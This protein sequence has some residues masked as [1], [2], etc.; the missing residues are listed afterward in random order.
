MVRV[1]LLR[2]CDGIRR[3]QVL[4]RGGCAI[5]H[6]Q[7]GVA[8]NLEHVRR[9]LLIA[10]LL[11]FPSLAGLWLVA[12]SGSYEAWGYPLLAIYLVWVVVAL[13]STRIRVVRILSTSHLVLSI[14]WLGLL[15][16]RLFAATSSASL[17]ERVTPDLYLLFALFS[18]VA[19]LAFRT[20]VALE[21]SAGLLAAT[22]V[23]A[24]AWFVW[25]LF[26][27]RPLASVGGIWTYEAMLGVTMLMVHALARSK[28]RHAAAFL[29]A[30]RLRDMAYTDPLTPLPNRR[31][32]EE[33]LEHAVSVAEALD[34]PL[35]VV[36]FGLDDFKRVNDM[37]G[38]AVGDAVLTEVGDAVRDVLR[39][40]DVFGRWGGEE[41]LIVAPAT[42]HEQAMQ[43]AERVR[44][45]LASREFAHS[46]RV[47]SSF[48]VAT[49]TTRHDTNTLVLTADHRLYQAKRAG[50]YRVA[51]RTAVYEA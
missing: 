35:S 7:M 36:F 13:A 5:G 47:T 34:R 32:L 24:G 50:K 2:A 31:E 6:T 41:Y 3:I 14:F 8:M 4:A 48:G 43:L 10:T 40:D 9:L 25:S 11:A 20:R 45:A 26:Q 46:V 27:G 28:D 38:H 42:S 39:A 30:A 29:E 19:H 12:S 18:V 49:S 51:G 17:S 22:A 44:R 33:G 15:A 21:A 16:C 37:H 1:S 23:V